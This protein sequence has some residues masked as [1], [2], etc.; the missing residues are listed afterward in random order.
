VICL[1]KNKKT[2]SFLILVLLM[3]G[4]WSHNG[5]SQSVQEVRIGVLAKRGPEIALKK[6]SATADYLSQA[7]PGYRF[8]IAALDFTEIHAAVQ[9]GTI[10]FVLANSAFYVELEKLYGVK[11]IATLLNQDSSGRQTTMFGGVILAR[12]DREDIRE[13]RDLKGKS[14]MAVEQRSFGGW[15]MCWRELHRMGLE[16]EKFF[17]SL[18]F[19]QTHDAVVAAVQRGDVDGG[20]VRTDTLERMA[21]GG[22]INLDDFHILNEQQVENFPFRISTSLYPEWPFAA[23]KDTSLDLAR[24]VASA[25]LA[26]KADAPAA[27]AGK[28]A[29]WTVALNYQPVHDCLMELRIGPYSDF[30]YFS[31]Y[32]VV[33]KYWLQLVLLFLSF[34][35]VVLTSLYILR[36][37]R[38]IR[39]KKEEV[40]ELNRTLEAKVLERTRKVNSLLDQELYLREIMETIAEVNG[41]LISAT[42]M[43]MLLQEAC[44]VMGEHGHYAY[45]WIGLLENNVVSRVFTSDDSVRFPSDPPYDPMDTEDSFSLTPAAHCMAKNQTVVVRQSSTVSTVSPWLDL[46][47]V[48]EY[49][50]VIS[51]PLRAD[52]YSSPLGA[53]SVYTLRLEGFEEEEIAMLEELAGDIGFAIN[54]FRQKEQVAKLERERTENYE[55]TILSF[56]NIIDHRDTYTAGHTTRVAHYC[57]LLAREM[58]L[59]EEETGILQKAAVLHDIGKI[60]TPD[61]VL[62]K[63]GKLSDLDYDLIKLHALAGYEILSGIGMYEDLA[64]IIR[65]H[66]ERY[67]GM[68]YPDHL[69][70]EGIPL[71]SR[72]LT[73]ADAFDAMTTNRIY[74]P[75]KAISEALQDLQRLS[76]SQFDPAVVAA[77][78]NVLRDVEVPKAISQLPITQM[79]QRRFSY[80]F[81]DKLTSLYNEDYLQIILQN[82]KDLHEY[83][84]LH[85]IHVKKLQQYNQHQGWESGNI[86]MQR[87]ALE[88]EETFPETLLFRAHGQYFI[89]I[90]REH[91]EI[92]AAELSFACLKETGVAFEL[93]HL[94]LQKDTVYTINNMDKFIV[95]SGED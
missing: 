17:S 9:E 95:Q 73:V 88:L 51:L 68:G 59:G 1:L 89:I 27:I 10:D 3:F 56:A 71:L 48:T 31:F 33:K 69:C 45:S 47:E 78:L 55:E 74:K 83:H 65:H 21:E 93:D 54:A 44:R 42:D 80:F 58:G 34:T 61:S 8:Q 22:D 19:G 75:R 77:A 13:I 14:F 38:R 4:N 43:D 15:I 76:G 70:G 91:F 82:N 16:P 62:L 53:F 67:D 64:V 24:Q 35:I 20:T 12:S 26:M 28:S 57:K 63:P 66:H 85:S 11:R 92:N 5:F 60:A 30:G 32:D 39:Q 7:L 36:L 94:D 72:V 84:C 52:Q 87:I 25:L 29:G 79:E 40:D 37:N 90:S 49:Q 2:I 86:L 46:A 50:S 18:Q 23:V 6:W 41:L 81:N